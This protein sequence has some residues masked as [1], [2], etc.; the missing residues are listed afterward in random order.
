[1]R[2]FL[3]S[4]AGR[5]ALLVALIASICILLAGATVYLSM[6]G[7]PRQLFAFE[8]PALEG[9]PAN[10]D[11]AG[12]A[13]VDR[14]SVSLGE[15]AKLRFR[16]LYRDGA[17][18]PDLDTF[19]RSM[20]TGRFSNVGI[21]VAQRSAAPGIREYTIEQTLQ[22]VAVVPHKSYQLDPVVLFYKSGKTV[23]DE[24]D[25]LRIA[26]PA[27][28]VSGAFPENASGFPL[29]ALREKISEPLRLRQGIVIACGVV[30]LLLAG[31][32]LWRLGYRRK[33]EEL[34][35][36]ERLWIEFSTRAPT[37]SDGRSYLLFCESIFTRLRQSSTGTSAAAFW[38][39]DDPDDAFWHRA[40]EEARSILRQGYRPGG[41]ATKDA[42]A[43]AALLKTTFAHV[44]AEDRLRREQEPSF[45]RR[46]WSQPAGLGFT[47]ACAVVAVCLLALGAMPHVWLSPAVARYAEATELARSDV[48]RM[49]A[50]TNLSDLSQQVG[51]PDLRAAALYNAGTALALLDPLNDQLVKDETSIIATFKD[52]PSLEPVVKSQTLLAQMFLGMREAVLSN[53]TDEDTRRNLELVTKRHRVVAAALVELLRMQEERF[54]L[55]LDQRNLLDALNMTL[56]ED[57]KDNDKAT[58]RDYYIGEKF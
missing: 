18:E 16:V 52:A 11:I 22:A 35:E 5:T 34:S 48:T 47:A 13:T 10:T 49:Q 14:D 42:E 8:T 9:L 40:S 31:I 45:L 50:A 6:T 29:R 51:V 26:A 4:A 54:V 33:P 25:K 53:P 43:M 46:L 56:Q 55:N 21:D 1:M 23:R 41:A 58:K 3:A 2:Q 38:T 32:L 44:V 36:A 12:W 27:I 30:L 7:Q 19:R 20:N 17:V 39:G 57:A 24:L 15:T 37:M 28:Y